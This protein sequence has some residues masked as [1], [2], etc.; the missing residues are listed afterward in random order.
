[1]AEVATDTRIVT[2]I[3]PAIA[4]DQVEQ[5]RHLV[6]DHATRYGTG[7]TLL[8]DD[9]LAE[10]EL[11]APIVVAARMLL[12]RT[13]CVP[14]LPALAWGI[15]ICAG[16][17]IPEHDHAATRYSCVYYLTRGAPLIVEGTQVD[18][19]PHVLAAFPGDAR[20]WTPQHLDGDRLSIGMSFG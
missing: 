18:I 7:G 16:V 12:R 10:H 20:H 1:M 8:T 5:L 4:D 15:R 9:K 13:W 19:E 6:L 3:E 11:V 14:D 2:C 17:T